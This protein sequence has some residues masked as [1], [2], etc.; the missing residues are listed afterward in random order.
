MP[1]LGRAEAPGAPPHPRRTCR[2]AVSFYPERRHTYVFASAQDPSGCVVRVVDATDAENPRAVKM[3]RR[4]VQAGMRC[5]PLTNLA[6]AVDESSDSFEGER[7]GEPSSS[8]RGLD[9]LKGLLP[10]N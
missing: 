2:I 3:F 8:T 4:S 1:A 9:D 10:G 5:A 7:P 6:R